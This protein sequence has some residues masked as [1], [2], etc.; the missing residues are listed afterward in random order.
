MLVANLRASKSN[1]WPTASRKLAVDLLAASRPAEA[2][3]LLGQ[4]YVAC[5][6]AK[7]PEAREVYLEWVEALLKANDP[8]IFKAMT[9]TAQV[10][11]FP[12]VL[13][14][15][16]KRVGELAAEGKFAPAILLAGEVLRQ[17]SSRLSPAQA[18]SFQKILDDAKARQLAVDRARVE[19]LAAQLQ[20]ADATTGKAAAAELKAMGDRAVGPLVEALRTVVA[21]AKP[22]PLAEKAIIDI[23]VQIAPKLTGY[24]VAEAKALKLKRIQEWVDGLKAVGSR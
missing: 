7:S 23:L 10:A 6:A 22:N 18:A 5:Q 9:D 17:L 2:A 3:P 4:A 11:E 14:K 13:E 20:S 1:L 16:E 12:G 19:Q 8:L 15:V 24:D 21:G